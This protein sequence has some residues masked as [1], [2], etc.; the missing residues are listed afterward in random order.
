MPYGSWR[1]GISSLLPAPF[2]AGESAVSRSV[3]IHVWLPS[4]WHPASSV[5]LLYTQ[6]AFK[7]KLKDLYEE[8]RLEEDK[9][10]DVLDTN[11]RLQLR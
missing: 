9:H 11:G 10:Q 4:P 6:A 3:S 8:V 2:I 5:P 1:H 7:L